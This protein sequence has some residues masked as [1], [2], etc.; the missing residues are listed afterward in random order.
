VNLGVDVQLPIEL[1]VFMHINAGVFNLESRMGRTR[2][3]Q[4]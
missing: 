3:R 4:M 1:R 2:L